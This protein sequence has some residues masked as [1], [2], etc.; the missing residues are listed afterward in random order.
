MSGRTT[1]RLCRVALL[2]YAVPARIERGRPTADFFDTRAI[3]PLV[4]A[5]IGSKFYPASRHVFCHGLG[6]I[7]IGV[8]VASL[9]DIEGFVPYL[10]RASVKRRDERTRDVLDMNDRLPRRAVRLQVDKTIS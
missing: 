4:R 2:P 1:G 7:A 8:I 5:R 6:Q 9:A 10:V 3:R